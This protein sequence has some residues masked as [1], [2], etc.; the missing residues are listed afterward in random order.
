M[1]TKSITFFLYWSNFFN[2]PYDVGRSRN[3]PRKA[4]QN[5][6]CGG[7]DCQ[8]RCTRNIILTAYRSCG[9]D[10]IGIAVGKEITHL[11]RTRANPGIGVTGS[12]R[13]VGFVNTGYL[14]PPLVPSDLRNDGFFFFFISFD[15]SLTYSCADAVETVDRTNVAR[16]SFGHSG[17]KTHTGTFIRRSRNPTK[18]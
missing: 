15:T 10:V 5:V 18:L 11:G 13:R 12:G 1:Y 16:A 2:V 7:H 4:E 3:L 8:Y 6:T 9:R 14:R 17:Q